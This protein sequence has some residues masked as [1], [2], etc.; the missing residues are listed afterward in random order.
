M[1]VCP[2]SYVDSDESLLSMYPECVH[3]VPAMH[4][5]NVSRLCLAA[6]QSSEPVYGQKPT[7]PKSAGCSKYLPVLKVLSCFSF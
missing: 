1:A 3:W 4:V 6:L 2:F 7:V 5:F